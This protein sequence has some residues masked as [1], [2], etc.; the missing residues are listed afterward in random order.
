MTRPHSSD[1]RLSPPREADQETATVV[2]V[3][4]ALDEPGLLQTVDQVRHPA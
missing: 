1:K 4:Y 2:R 3:G